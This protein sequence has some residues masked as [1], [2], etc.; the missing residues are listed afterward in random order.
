MPAHYFDNFTSASQFKDPNLRTIP[1]AVG[2]SQW[3]RDHLLACHVIVQKQRH[4]IP[5]ILEEHS[6]SSDAMSSV[7]IQ[8]FVKG[9]KDINHFQQSEHSL[10]RDFG[11]ST[12]LAQTWSALATFK[13]DRDPQRRHLPDFA[14]ADHSEDSNTD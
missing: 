2:A 13:G 14:D 12:S 8:N 1:P 9:P 10:V 7:E 6:E 11:Y 5:P 3:K 4:R